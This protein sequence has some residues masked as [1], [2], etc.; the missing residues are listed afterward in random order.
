VKST[1]FTVRLNFQNE[2]KSTVWGREFRQFITRS[3]NKLARKQFMV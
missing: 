2:L 1:R 3:L